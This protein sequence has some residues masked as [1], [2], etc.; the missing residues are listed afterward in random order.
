M[1]DTARR[2]YITLYSNIEMHKRYPETNSTC[3]L[4]NNRFEWCIPHC[5]QCGQSFIKS[6]LSMSGVNP[7]GHFVPHMH[8][9]DHTEKVICLCNHKCVELY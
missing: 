6:S 5:G 7:N 1:A 4:E 3:K 2:C 8:I 9:T